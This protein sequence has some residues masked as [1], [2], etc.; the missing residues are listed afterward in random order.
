[1]IEKLNFLGFPKIKTIIESLKNN[2]K[3]IH[4][5]TFFFFFCIFETLSLS[6][7]QFKSRVLVA[8]FSLHESISPRDASRAHRSVTNISRASHSYI[9]KTDHSGKMV[10]GNLLKKSGSVCVRVR[11]GQNE[12]GRRRES[13]EKERGRKGA[14]EGERERE[15]LI[16]SYKH[17]QHQ[18]P[19]NL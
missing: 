13:G 3:K 19:K 16:K 14:R 6:N 4:F 18:I 7:P 8:F 11:E 10:W 5:N 9:T 15:R 12:R 1:M 17:L 2:H